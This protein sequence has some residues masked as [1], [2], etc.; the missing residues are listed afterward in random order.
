MN[1]LSCAPA[2]NAVAGPVPKRDAACMAA[3]KQYDG[4]TGEP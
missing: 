4:G 1:A 3:Q 2:I